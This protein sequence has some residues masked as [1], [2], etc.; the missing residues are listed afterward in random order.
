MRCIAIDHS[1]EWFAT[2]S[3]DR[4]IKIWDLASGKLRLSLTGHIAAVRDLEISKRHAYL[5]SCGEDKQIKCWVN[6]GNN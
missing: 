4:M 2:G 3:A 1:N 5:F 6:F